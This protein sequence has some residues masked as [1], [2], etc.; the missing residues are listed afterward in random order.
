MIKY[1]SNRGGG[2]AVDF[3]TAIL[4]G[5]AVDGGLYVP[6]RL[7][8][9]SIETLNEWKNLS[10]KEIAFEVLS[11][12][13]DRNIVSES[14][15][16]TILSKAYSSFEKEEVIP[17][18]PL[19][20][21][22]DFYIMEL[23][24]GPTLSFKDVG[25]AFLVNLFDFFLQRRERKLS[26]IVATTGDTGPATASF[27]AG[28]STL[29][30]WV[31]YPK[32]R[33]T[34]EQ[35][36]QMTTLTESNVN[37]VG[38]YNCPEGGDDLDAVIAKLYTN[39]SFKDK[40]NLSSV[41]SINWGRVMMQTVHYFYGYL[42]IVDSIGEKINI[43]V[44]SGGFGN[45]CAGGLARKMGLPVK[46]FVIANNLNTCLHRTFSKGLFS[47]EPIHQTVSSAID[48][49]TP[50]NFW[51]FLYFC[52][53]GNSA[54]I[55]KWATQFEETG[56]VQFDQ[57]TFESYSNGFLSIGIDDYETLSTIRNI[58]ENEAYLL[59]PH[60]AVAVSAAKRLKNQLG[61]EK[62]ICLATAHPAKFPDTIR[63]ALGTNSL[64]TS[65]SHYSIEISKSRC[66]KGYSADCAH[67]EE[68]LIHSMESYW[69]NT[70]L[71]N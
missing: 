62:L 36:R 60:G 42:Q 29:D 15:L 48:I 30:A 7:P 59:D 20:S 58:Y 49:L 2:T 19:F 31:L 12:F 5:F 67:L 18:H 16:K 68:A 71:S 53:D 13:I 40:V 8:H 46:N 45:L 23:F 24:Y 56:Q 28:K 21:R 34:E 66:Q 38:V 14:E 65:A 25:L 43:A 54:L 10:Y 52:V 26:V 32:G 70:T 51:R 35:E 47:K 11:L 33:I 41:N 4:D 17:L 61:K 50:F 57:N 39:K 64:P 22:N 69:E 6:E 9:V 1:V 44:P 55:H 63:K 3:E 37:P 27:I